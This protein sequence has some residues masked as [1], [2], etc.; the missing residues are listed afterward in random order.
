MAR[1]RAM[2]VEPGRPGSA[3]VDEVPDPGD[4]VGGLAVRG[5]LV[6]VC[7]T[8]REIAEGAY[9]EPP[10]GHAKL[11][12]GHEGL[13]EVLDAP[14]DSGFQPGDL[15]VGIVRR[16][17]PVPCPACAAGEWDMCRNDRFS[18]RGIVRADGYGSERWR[19]DPEFAIAIPRA[20]GELG[21]LLEPASVLAK[22]WEQ[23]DRISRR[24][25]FVGRRVLVT[26][27]G[28]IGLLACLLGVQRGYEV[29]AVDLAQGGAKRDL[30]E[31]L[32]ARYHAGD[33]AD[34]DV[35]FD[36]VI[37][38]TGIGAVGRSAAGRVISGGI[39]CLTGIMNLD[40]NLDTDATALNRAMVLH[41]QVLFG[42][43]N[44][45][46]RHWEQAAAALAAADREWLAGMITRR[47]PLTRWTEALERKPD[48]I[49][50]VVDLA[51]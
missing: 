12:I 24:A 20:L 45:G 49:K 41:N 29:Y 30:V 6:G 39:M 21:V 34:I 32:G 42:T 40:A 43:V 3:T 10:S 2:T 37:E 9:G 25:F 44:A 4:E 35:E 15:V 26:G 1:V 28:P 8:D 48:D 22:A 14:A 11:I 51:A 7:G 36:V 33:A 23:V 16:P 13:G 46:R 31:K 27:A 50:V 47:V 18:E 38:C 5:L 19:L 17:D